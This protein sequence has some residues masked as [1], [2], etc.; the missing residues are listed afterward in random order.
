MQTGTLTAAER[1]HL[2][3]GH[4][5]FGD[6]YGRD[7]GVDWERMRADWAA[8]RDALLAEWIR[9]RPRSR[10]FAWWVFD[11]PER[12]QTADGAV[13]PFDDPAVQER[14]R[15]CIAENPDS[16]FERVHRGLYFG[17]PQI[18]R[19]PTKYESE[20]EYLARLGLLFP[21]ESDAVG[22]DLHFP[23]LRDE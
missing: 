13:H 3:T 5:F 16:W 22:T 4:D 18:V 2:Q 10:P 7:D 15:Q 8:H 9:H 21:G 17:R 23:R 1:Y 19:G 12:R 14:D 20:G 11:A 6:G